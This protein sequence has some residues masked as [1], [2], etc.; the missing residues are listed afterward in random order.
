MRFRVT[1]AY[2]G[3]PF[4]GWQSQAGGNTIQDELETAAAKISGAARVPFH[5]AGRTDAGVH[6]LAQVAH[7][8]APEDSRLNSRAWLSA[9]N[10]HLPPTIRLTA[11][12]EAAP[13]FHARFDADGKTYRYRIFHGAILS[14][15]EAGRVWHLRRAIDFDL[16][17]KLAAHFVGSHDFSAFAGFRGSEPKDCEP[18]PQFTTRTIHEID[19]DSGSEDYILLTFQGDG[20]LYHMVRLITGSLLQTATGRDDFDRV[21]DLLESPAGRKTSICAPADGL[22]LIQVHYP[23]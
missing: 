7:F 9:L 19:I 20:F 8:D 15:F 10:A 5:G 6:A 3:Q 12:A 17:R 4:R 2:D 22:Y 18:D 1:V 13:D 23:E 16:L 14:P 21:V 11:C